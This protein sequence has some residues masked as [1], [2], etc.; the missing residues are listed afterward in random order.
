[1]NGFEFDADVIIVGGGLNGPVVALALAQAGLSVTLCDAAL[2]QTRADPDF[3]GRAYSL[4]LASQRLLDAIGAWA[5]VAPHAQPVWDVVVT[6]GR[7]GEAPSP[8][9]LHFDHREMD[10]GAG[11]FMVEDRHLRPVLLAMV[12]AHPRITHRAP[13]RVASHDRSG[14]GAAVT[15]DGGEVIRARVLIACDGKTSPIAARERITRLKSDYGQTGLVCAVGHR[16]PHNGVAYEHFL[17][18]G[19]FAILPLQG[20]RA[21]LVWTETTKEAA[22]IAALPDAA[23]LDEVAQRFG[24]FLGPLTLEGGRWSYPLTLSLADEWVR[25]KLALL[26]DAAHAVHP[27][28]GQGLNLGLR[29]AAALA[30]VLVDAHRRGE[31]IGAIDVLRRY[32]SWRRFD[33]VSLALGMDALNRLFSNDA[34]GLRLLRD[35]GMAL[36]G[37]LVP[38]RRFFMRQAAGIG[39]GAPRL[40]EG[41]K[42]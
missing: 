29:D 32:E 35:A 21:S 7:R 40:M 11:S 23:Y 2:A 15:L 5:A 25:P 42:L 31:D 39:H 6:D 27:I 17:P 18:S 22:R 38:A 10:E 19:P 14:I 26:G 28:A 34:P 37:A 4:A 3:D 30:E 33:T 36:A 16:D 20:N 24:D 1:M 13:A 12:E 8:L 41:R 9:F